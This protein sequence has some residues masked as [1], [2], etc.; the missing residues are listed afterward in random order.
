[1]LNS[2][3]FLLTKFKISIFT[4]PACNAS[5]IFF[6][7]TFLASV[8]LQNYPMSLFSSEIEAIDISS[9]SARKISHS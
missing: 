2:F 6:Q 3:L 5:C 1:M 7:A 8:Y 4:E 9:P